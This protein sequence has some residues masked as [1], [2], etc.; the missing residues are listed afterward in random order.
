MRWT[1]MER[2]MR[3]YVNRQVTIPLDAFIH[4]LLVVQRV[5]LYSVGCLFCGTHQA[6]F[7]FMH[8]DFTT[9]GT[10]CL[11]CLTNTPWCSTGNF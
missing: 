9:C 4:P 2:T 11:I 7:R 6:K 5:P 8:D 10:I 1:N 3:V